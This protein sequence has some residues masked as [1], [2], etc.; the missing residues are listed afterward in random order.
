MTAKKRTIAALAALATATALG[1]CGNKEKVVT[2]GATEGAYLDVDSL[3]YQVQISRELNPASLEDHTFLTGLAPQDRQI[4]SDEEWFAVFVRVENDSKRTA[5]P[6]T[7]YSIADTQGNVYRPVALSPAANPFAYSPRPLGG[8]T[9]LPPVNSVAS[10]TSINGEELLFKIKRQSL[11]NR[12]LTFFIKSA[13]G[14]E[15]ASVD[16]DV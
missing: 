11:D 4:A 12:P 14:G 16:L 5:T 10:Q 3:K 6:T 2:H 9:L 15:A 1:A 7:D 8:G 13:S